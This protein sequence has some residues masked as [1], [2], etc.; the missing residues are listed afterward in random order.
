MNNFDKK[1]DNYLQNF[2]ALASLSL[3]FI[4]GIAFIIYGSRKFPL[5]PEGLVEYYDLHPILASA[6]ALS[7]LLS[8]III[9]IEAFIKNPLGNILTRLA[10]LNIVLLMSSI[11][12][13]AHSD[14][15]ITTKLFSS[16]QIF[17]LVSGLFFFIKGNNK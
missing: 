4:L 12:I 8:G 10:G 6:V 2:E 7:E 5:P 11:L 3:R 14:W 9:I 15:F 17:L 16:V 13:V 1:I